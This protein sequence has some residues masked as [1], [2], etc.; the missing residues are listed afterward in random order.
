MR[1]R[2]HIRSDYVE[3]LPEKETLTGGEVVAYSDASAPL[4]CLSGANRLR[5]ELSHASL[6]THR[7][8]RSTGLDPMDRFAGTALDQSVWIEM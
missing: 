6:L 5:K 2:S 7:K 3:T 4:F 1:V 8:A